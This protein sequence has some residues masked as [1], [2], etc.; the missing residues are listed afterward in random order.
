MIVLFLL[1]LIIPLI[2]IFFIF[3]T[4]SFAAFSNIFLFLFFYLMQHLIKKILFHFS[5]QKEKNLL[6]FV[7]KVAKIVTPENIF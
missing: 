3:L 7:V 1:T 6:Y 2:Y 4:F 5:F